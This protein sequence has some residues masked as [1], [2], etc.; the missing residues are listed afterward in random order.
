MMEIFVVEL[1]VTVVFRF[2]GGEDQ[3]YCRKYIRVCRCRARLRYRIIYFNR[4]LNN[5]LRIS[6]RA[7]VVAKISLHHGIFNGYIFSITT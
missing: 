7:R 3:F 2:Y 6:A 1:F 5:F 4:C